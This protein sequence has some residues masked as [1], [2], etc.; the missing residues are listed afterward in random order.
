MYA[1]SLSIQTTHWII[2]NNCKSCCDNKCKC[3]LLDAEID[4]EN[5]P[6][7]NMKNRGKIVPKNMNKFIT[8]FFID[9]YLPILK[10][11][12]SS[13]LLKILFFSLFLCVR[14]INVSSRYYQFSTSLKN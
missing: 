9:N 2:D 14:F 13:Y 3:T 8:H 4:G 5:D 7:E 10:R 12:A 6:A 1:L 11:D